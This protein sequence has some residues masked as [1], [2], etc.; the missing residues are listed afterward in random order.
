VLEWCYRGVTGVLQ[1]VYR[2]MLGVYHVR[3]SRDVVMFSGAV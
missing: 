3:Y 2:G 1:G